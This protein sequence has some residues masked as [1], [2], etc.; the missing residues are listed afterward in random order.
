VS[1][2]YKEPSF[3]LL[4][5][6][7]DP[8][9]KSRLETVKETLVKKFQA[10]QL[11]AFLLDRVEIYYGAG[12]E[13]QNRYEIITELYDEDRVTVFLFTEG[14]L[15]DTV[16]MDVEHRVDETVYA[17]LKQRYNII[18]FNRIPV[19]NKLNVLMRESKVIFLIREKEETRGGEYLEL[20]HA[21]FEGHGEKIWSMVKNN[22]QLSQ[23]LLEY[24][25][26]FGVKIRQYN[27]PE[28]LCTQAERIL[29]Y[30]LPS[31]SQGLNSH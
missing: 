30:R 13:G 17:F 19:I 1:R 18:Q 5:G 31:S 15:L 29:S 10:E 2:L 9:T 14:H 6:S 22:I 16:D 21:L 4:L 25:D 24:L 20:M 11:F 23:M 8:L 26:K 28:D 7:Y 27:S 3:I 12:S